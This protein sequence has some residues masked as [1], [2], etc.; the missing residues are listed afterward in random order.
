[1]VVDSDAALEIETM[2]ER[3]LEDDK[4]RLLFDLL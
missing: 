1:M 2:E 4:G 3:K